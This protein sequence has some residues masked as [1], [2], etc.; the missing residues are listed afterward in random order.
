MKFLFKKT[1]WTIFFTRDYH[2]NFHSVLEKKIPPAQK[3]VL[4]ENFVYSIIAFV[5]GLEVRG[6]WRGCG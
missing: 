1:L 2:Q 4:V 6:I 3:N 5:A